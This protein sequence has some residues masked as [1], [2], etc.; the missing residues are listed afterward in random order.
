MILLLMSI[1]ANA[2]KALFGAYFCA[3]QPEDWTNGA[4]AD[5]QAIAL[6]CRNQ[7]FR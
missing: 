6:N 2:E 1:K 7:L 3:P 5:T 4:S